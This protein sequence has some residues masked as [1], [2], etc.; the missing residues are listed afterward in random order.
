[1]NNWWLLVAHHINFQLSHCEVRASS[2]NLAH[3]PWLPIDMRHSL[4][5]CQKDFKRITQQKKEMFYEKS[6]AKKHLALIAIKIPSP[7]AWREQARRVSKEKV[8]EKCLRL[9][10]TAFC[11]IPY[12]HSAN[13]YMCR[14]I[15]E[16]K[17]KSG[18]LSPHPPHPHTISLAACHITSKTTNADFSCLYD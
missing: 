14:W 16:I 10:S 6:G 3:P 17:N 9:T 11:V 8:S 13:S 2:R 5:A 1:M 12:V 7:K 15:C 4:C 18:S